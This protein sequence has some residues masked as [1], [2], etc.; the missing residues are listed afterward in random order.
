MRNIR[1]TPRGYWQA[2]RTQA[3]SALKFKEYSNKA[4]RASA[5]PNQMASV[6]ATADWPPTG[7][8]NHRGMRLLHMLSASTSNA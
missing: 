8:S 7:S 4:G 6:L 2:I 1:S 5:E 3:T